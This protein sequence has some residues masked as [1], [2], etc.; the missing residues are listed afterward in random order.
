MVFITYT[1]FSDIVVHNYD[2]P[3]VA[4]S[5]IVLLIL[6]ILIRWASF[7]ERPSGL[8]VPAILLVIYGLVGFASLLYATD[9]SVVSTGTATKRPP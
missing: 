7:N 8:Q 9:E 5:F 6:A 3:S 2:A 1:R 4:K